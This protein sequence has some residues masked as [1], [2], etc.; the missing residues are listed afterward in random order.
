[1]L[2]IIHAGEES[3]EQPSTS[4]IPP[5]E[6]SSSKEVNSENCRGILE[7]TIIKV[8]ENGPG[9]YYGFNREQQ[10]V[11]KAR[12]WNAKPSRVIVYNKGKS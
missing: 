9:S 7:E 1:M 12:K 11:K 6:N 2:L 4:V 8:C 10:D 3:L 5:P